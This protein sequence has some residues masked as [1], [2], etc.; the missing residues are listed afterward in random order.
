MSGSRFPRVLGSNLITCRLSFWHMTYASARVAWSKKEERSRKCMWQYVE[1]CHL[2]NEHELDGQRKLYLHTDAQC[3]LLCFSNSLKIQTRT[4]EQ[5]NLRKTP[6]RIGRKHFATRPCEY[7][8]MTHMFSR[9]IA[10][11][12]RELRSPINYWIEL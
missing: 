6:K 11:T 5:E 7:E 9:W 3:L 4:P 2:T 12:T 1:H 8:N 10:T